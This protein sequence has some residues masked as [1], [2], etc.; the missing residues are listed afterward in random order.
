MP[1]YLKSQTVDQLGFRS[2]PAYTVAGTV[3]IP[4][5]GTIDCSQLSQHVIL[6]QSSATVATKFHLTNYVPGV[7]LH[8]TV[9]NRGQSINLYAP[10]GAHINNTFQFIDLNEF[11]PNST[12]LFIYDDT[13]AY[14][15]GYKFT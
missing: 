4:D 6:L 7:V 9:A 15:T 10:P 13:S 11:L 1:H 2:V 14:S 8:F 3:V 12:S 5:N